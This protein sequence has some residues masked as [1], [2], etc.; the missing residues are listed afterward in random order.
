M[1][2]LQYNVA[3]LFYGDCLH[4]EAMSVKENSSP[5]TPA[6]LSLA[7]G[8]SQLIRLKQNSL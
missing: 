5:T 4:R 6:D 8:L 3:A 7:L 1:N 2:R